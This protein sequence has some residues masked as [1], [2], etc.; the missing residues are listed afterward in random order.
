MDNWR[1]GNL[2]AGRASAPYNDGRRLGNLRFME[3]TN[4]GR[5]NMTV[6]GMVI[7]AGP[8]QIGRHH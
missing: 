3:A 4:E 6:L 2:T 7:V 8:I 5:H 1:R